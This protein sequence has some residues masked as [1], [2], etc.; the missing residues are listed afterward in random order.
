MPAPREDR[1]HAP[2]SPSPDALLRQAA[3]LQQAGRLDEAE[4]LYRETERLDPGNAFATHYLGVIAMQ[5]GDAALGARLMTRALLSRSDVP[6]FHTNLGLCHKRL[7]ELAQAIECYRRAIVLDPQSFLAHNN[8]A[9]AL[10]DA[11]RIPEA[12]AAFD[13]ALAL[14]PDYAEAHYNRGLACLVSGDFARGWPEY[15]WRAKCREF[16][17]RD[18]EPAGLTPWRGE[19]LAG[20]TL[21]V[22]REQGH[23]DTFQFLRFMPELAD[24]GAHLLVE[25]PDEIRELAKTVDPRITF[26]E[27]GRSPSSVDYYVNLMSVPRWLGVTLETLARSAPYLQP[28]PV[29]VRA[30]QSRLR[31]YP[32]RKVGLVWGGNP[33]HHNDR[34][35]SCPLSL[36]KALTELDGCS[37][38]SL[39]HGPAAG[40]LSSLEGS[41]IVDLAGDLPA[42]SDTAAA[43]FA[44]D[45]VVTV[46]TSVAHLAGAT[47]RTA[48]VLVPYAPDWRWLRDRPDSPWYPTLR[49]FR[50]KTAGDW[51]AVIDD[52]R[53]ALSDPA[54]LRH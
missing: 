32:G 37:W 50:Q 38:F 51:S 48:W 15:E 26:V 43:L 19:P 47:G 45:L 10:L 13:R 29:R 53:S 36:M 6:D 54:A 3:I 8:L 41:R 12:L 14:Q 1:S 2:Q 42:Y 39:Q 33:G 31:A 18:L 28:D 5:R 49:L 7:G 16:A 40:Q 20:K 46:D 44:L 4:A 25:V 11:G 9:V 17:N 24:R 23:G 22:R 52:I 30:W 27:P 35:R 21:L 34:N